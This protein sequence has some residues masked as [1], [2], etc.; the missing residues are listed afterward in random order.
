MIQFS[1]ETDLSFT[2]VNFSVTSLQLLLGLLL[3]F[4]VTSSVGEL[5]LR[6]SQNSNVEQVLE[7][8]EQVDAQ[9]SR[10]RFSTD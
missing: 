10:E 1:F 5:G 8:S 9:D 6:V 3:L 2:L 4:V 7:D